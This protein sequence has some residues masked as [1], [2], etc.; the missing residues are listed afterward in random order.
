MDPAEEFDLFE[1]LVP[2]RMRAAIASHQ[3]KEPGKVGNDTQQLVNQFGLARCSSEIAEGIDKWNVGKSHVSGLHAR[4]DQHAMSPALRPV[5]KFHEKPRLTHSCV[6]ADEPECAL[7][8]IG[9]VEE[10]R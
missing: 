8:V 10:L 6:A 7:I 5:G 4:A 2:R 9:P 1:L 3:G